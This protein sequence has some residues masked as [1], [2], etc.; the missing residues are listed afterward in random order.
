MK[1]AILY[2]AT[3]A[4][5]VLWED[6]YRTAKANF[7]SED[8]V[9][10]FVFTDSS[11]IRESADTSILFQQNLGWPF[12][13]LYRYRIFQRISQELQDFDRVVFFNANCLF[14]RPVCSD[15]FFGTCQQMRLVACRHPAFYNAPAADR[16]YER[17]QE[18][19]ACVHDQQIYVQG[20]LM[21]GTPEAFLGMCQQL[22]R[23]IEADLDSGIVAVWHDESHWNAFL[24]NNFDELQH[25]LH[26]LSP[27][28]LYPEDWD[29]PFEPLIQL[30]EKSKHFDVGSIKHVVSSPGAGEERSPLIRLQ[31]LFRRVR[32]HARR[33]LSGQD[34]ESHQ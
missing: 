16:P 24:N 33:L 20:A 27:A 14:L 6:F 26:L 21:G 8:T 34:A 19:K 15:D 22:H 4:Y 7:C 23:N 9:H 10:F 1:I 2:I 11:L 13:S 3:G 31:K 25:Q 32:H 29:L 18:S 12:A 30:R 28:Y 5:A 17:R